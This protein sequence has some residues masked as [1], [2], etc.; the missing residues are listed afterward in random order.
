VLRIHSQWH[1][2]HDFFIDDAQRQLG[3][4]G[5]GDV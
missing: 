5:F 2:H 3:N 1:F 4:D